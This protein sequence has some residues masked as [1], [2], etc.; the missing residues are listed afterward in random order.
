M[1][2]KPAI[3]FALAFIGLIAVAYIALQILHGEMAFDAM[4]IGLLVA[5]GAAILAGGAVVAM[6]ELKSSH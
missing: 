2:T 3:G 6:E 5:A 1:Y 4:T